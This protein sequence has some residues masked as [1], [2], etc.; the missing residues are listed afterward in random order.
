[1]AGR[2]QHLI[3]IMATQTRFELN[4]AV[5]NWR[6]ELAAQP[7]L[8]PDA[9]RELEKHLAD[10][11]AELRSRGLNDEESFWL[12]S[13]RIGQPQQLAEEFHK[14]DVVKVWR[15]RVF[16]AWLALFL[17]R[18]SESVFSSIATLAFRR[19]IVSANHHYGLMQQV[20]ISTAV[21]VLPVLILLVLAVSLAKGKLILQLSRVMPL[22]RDRR[23]LAT[24]TFV[25]I[26]MSFGIRAIAWTSYINNSTIAR[27]YFLTANLLPPTIYAILMGVVLIWLYPA[28]S[29]VRHTEKP[30]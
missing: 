18:I 28:K 5:E 11:M 10:S 22:I 6:N 2:A 3:Q 9:R 7:H 16:W 26:L 12:A 24:I 25:L 17:W 19:S 8:T 14:V 21:S 4:A 27:T 29:Q 1:M 15:E 20:M 13:R 30:A 23:R